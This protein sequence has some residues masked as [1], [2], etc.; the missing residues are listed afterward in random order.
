MSRFR[1]CERSEAIQQRRDGLLRYAR[2]D[3]SIKCHPDLTPLGW[4]ASRRCTRHSPATGL[5]NRAQ[6]SHKKGMA[7]K[8][9]VFVTLKPG[10]LDPQ[11]RAIQHALGGLGFAGVEGV[12]A[13]R[14]IELELADYTTEE[15]VRAMCEKLLAN[16][17]IE[18]FRIVGF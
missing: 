6:R 13:G 17:V 7:V 16:T 15:N 18:N 3:D 2:N 9:Q 4:L 8:I 1:H 11:G 12:R 10:V 14:F 5:L